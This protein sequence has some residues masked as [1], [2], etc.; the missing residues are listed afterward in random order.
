MARSSPQ[1]RGVSAGTEKF[2]IRGITKR[3]GS[4]ERAQKCIRLYTLLFYEFIRTALFFTITV[5]GEAVQALKEMNLQ[6]RLKRQLGR[7]Y[8]YRRQGKTA[9]PDGGSD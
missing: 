8:Y 7:V 6:K 3:T 4:E 5:H 1:E 9:S 2:Y